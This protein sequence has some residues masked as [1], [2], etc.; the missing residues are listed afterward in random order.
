[1]NLTMV[2]LVRNEA[3][4]L[5]RNIEFHLNGEVDSIVAI[6]NGSTDGTREILDEFERSRDVVVIDEPGRDMSQSAWVSDAAAYA[7]DVIKADWIFSNDAD[8]F[9]FWPK[10]RL[11]EELEKDDA[12]VLTLERVN[13][14]YAWDRDTSEDWARK[15]RFRVQTPE[16]RL[17]LDDIYDSPFPIPHVYCNLPS[18]VMFRADCF[19]SV[20]QGNHAITANRDVRKQ[21]SK[22][23]VVHFPIRS[24]AQFL[25][26]IEQFGA[27]YDRNATL[28]ERAGWQTLRWYRMIQS[29]RSEAALA[30]ALPA[31]EL[32]ES[33]LAQGRVIDDGP[34]DPVLAQSGP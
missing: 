21:T 4:I 9:W 26:K 25:S 3:D 34:F 15:L 14:F 12:D 18:K 20:L 33:D 28:S 11:K 29:G 16:P 7:R 30:E 1:M 19:S 5:A 6:D 10:C 8:E 17:R 13:M 22:G 2:L 31:Q 27:A 32:L 23:H 24:N